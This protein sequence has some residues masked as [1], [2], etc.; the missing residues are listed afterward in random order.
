[1]RSSRRFSNDVRG[2]SIVELGIVI[3]VISVL[4]SVVLVSRG[5]LNSAKQKTAGDL[6]QTLREAGREHAKRHFKGLSF[7]T[8][9]QTTPPA[10]SMQ[11]LRGAGQVPENVRTPWKSQGTAKDSGVSIVPD[12]G[13]GTPLQTK[14]ADYTCMRI[15]METPDKENCDDMVKQF[16]NIALYAKCEQSGCGLTGHVVNII[17]R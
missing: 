10:L 2:F 1:M 14:C 8:P 4:A 11:A 16:Q 6:V 17:S 5:Y 15:C 12:N 3:T 9:G 7:G 13:V